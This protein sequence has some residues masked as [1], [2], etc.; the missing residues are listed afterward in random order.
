MPLPTPSCSSRYSRLRCAARNV[1]E[2]CSLTAILILVLLYSWMAGCTPPHEKK[3]NPP[4]ILV[5]GF[6]SNNELLSL[7]ICL[8]PE[9][10]AIL[11]NWRTGEFTELKPRNPDEMWTSAS[12]SHDDRFLVLT[13]K[14][15][16]EGFR[17]SQLAIYDRQ[18]EALRVLTHS[19]VYKL[20][21]T[22]SPEGNRLI[23]ARAGRERKEG[24]TQHADWDVY[25]MSIETKEEKPLTDYRFYLID[26]PHYMADGKRFVFSGHGPSRFEN[27]SGVDARNNYKMKFDDNRVFIRNAG[28]S[29]LTP[30]LTN[31]IDTRAPSLSRDDSISYIART[32]EMDGKR[33]PYNYDIFLFKKSNHIRLT[34]FNAV[35]LRQEISHDG[36]WLAYVADKKRNRVEELFVMNIKERKEIRIQLPIELLFRDNHQKDRAQ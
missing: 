33:D 13:V 24:K 25:E 27:K 1:S 22:F 11:L 8:L 29:E 5:N 6:S 21:P 17:T 15:K 18:H 2:F 31:G 30:A 10:R 35:V 14:Q 19:A 26:R 20:Y 9:C 28:T 32:N 4:A 3:A 16:S 36:N 12:F 7:D 34:N 23:Y